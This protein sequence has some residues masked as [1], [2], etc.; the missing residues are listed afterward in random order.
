MLYSR[1]KD[2]NMWSFDLQYNI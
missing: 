1:S 2:R